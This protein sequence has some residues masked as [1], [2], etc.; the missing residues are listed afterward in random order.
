MVF[1]TESRTNVRLV[2][3]FQ[4]IA[5]TDAS[6]VAI[7]THAIGIDVACFFVNARRAR[8]PSTIHVRFIEVFFTVAATST[9][10]LVTG[11]QLCIGEMAHPTFA[12][13][14]L[15]ARFGG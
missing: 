1:K 15:I 13:T 8:R 4:P 10:T 11:G 12:V 2:P 3:V 7:A 14:S 9:D 5:A 6:G